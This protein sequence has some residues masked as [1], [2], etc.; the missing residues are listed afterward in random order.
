MPYSLHSNFNELHAFVSSI[1]PSYLHPI[2]QNYPEQER[3]PFAEV[4]AS[5]RT[6]NYYAELHELR[7][8]Y[9]SQPSKEYAQLMA[10][11]ELQR[12]IM[13]QLEPP[14]PLSLGG[15]RTLQPCNMQTNERKRYKLA[16]ARNEEEINKLKQRLQVKRAALSEPPSRLR[17]PHHD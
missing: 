7:T 2:V 4:S 12:Q 1:R 16:N 9:C 14:R 8:L 6:D 15:E 11:C 3:M 5:D 17:P 10:D 13:K